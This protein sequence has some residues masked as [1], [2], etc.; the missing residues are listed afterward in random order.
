M[1]KQKGMEKRL[2]RQLDEADGHAKD[3][4]ENLDG[5]E[6]LG[7]EVVQH[8]MEVRD[9]LGV[10]LFIQSEIFSPSS[11]SLSRNISCVAGL[12]SLSANRRRIVG[13]S[14]NQSMT[15]PTMPSVRPR[16]PTSGAAATFLRRWADSWSRMRR[17]SSGAL[18]LIAPPHDLLGHELP[19]L[20]VFQTRRQRFVPER[21][22]PLGRHQAVQQTVR[23]GLD[24]RHEKV[25]DLLLVP[26]E[27]LQRQPLDLSNHVGPRQIRLNLLREFRHERGGQQQFRADLLAHLPRDFGLVLRN[28][29]LPPAPV[30]RL[31]L[32]RLE[33]HE[34][35]EPVRHVTQR[36]QDQFQPRKPPRRRLF[37]RI[38]DNPPPQSEFGRRLFSVPVH[39]STIL[40]DFDFYLLHAKIAWLVIHPRI[41]RQRLP[42]VKRFR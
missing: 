12:S 15:K 27:H 41:S 5:A 40:S 35:G 3:V 30:P 14:A 25:D 11:R 6:M 20:R 39:A 23:G 19:R 8:P 16:S 32:I 37:L 18:S 22:N 17:T 26:S 33:E 4:A 10:D 36:Q 7:R 29:P 31:P 1:G 38:Y 2:C 28:Q 42:F 9:V 24:L 13:S 21:A 34:N